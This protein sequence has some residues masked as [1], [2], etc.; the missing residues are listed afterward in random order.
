MLWRSKSRQEE[1]E[2]PLVSPEICD[3]ILK[4]AN[5]NPLLDTPI[6][7]GELLKLGIKI[8]K[9]IVSNL[10]NRRVSKSPSQTWRTSEK[11]SHGERSFR[12]FIHSSRCPLPD[13]FRTLC[14]IV[15]RCCGGQGIKHPPVFNKLIYDIS[16]LKGYLLYF[17][18]TPLLISEWFDL[19]LQ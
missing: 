11:K 4:M 12:W 16:R 10:M 18:P 7:H 13:F 17:T 6:I 14:H 1:S 2:R 3:F 8:S 19:I 9:R 15:R 5:A